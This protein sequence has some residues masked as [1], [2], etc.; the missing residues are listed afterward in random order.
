VG[1]DEGGVIAEFPAVVNISKSLPAVKH[2]VEHI[3]ETLCP[4]PVASRYR[5]L[6]PEK[7]E[8]ARAEFAELEKQG[9]VRRSSSSWSSP[10]HMVPKADGSWRP[11]GDYRRLNLVTVPD[12]YP[13]PHMEDLS[14]RLA[15][16]VIFSKLDLRKG[17][18]Q[19]PV[20]EK[21]VAK[22]AIITPFGLFEFLRMPFGLRNAGQSFQRLMDHIM[23]GLQHVFVYMDD[24]LVASKSRAEHH[25][26][27]REVMKRLSTHGLVLNK[28]KCV[29]YASEVEYL[30]H[31]VSAKGIR[32]LAAR[33]AAIEDFPP[34][35]T[36]GE[37][38]RFLGMV[39]YYRRFV[40]G[41]AA[42]LKPLTDA[43]RGPGGQSTQIVM[44]DDMCTAFSEA[45]MALV[46]AAV[47]V[48]PLPSA[49]ISL[50]VDA[51]DKHVG[52]GPA[53]TG[54]RSV[55]PFGLLQQKVD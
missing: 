41:A 13:P 46:K 48:H 27:V 6:D 28:E 42:I 50:A 45:K 55:A 11:C 12:M 22:T 16:K 31:N 26:H 32:P 38:Q 49:E 19:V 53:A 35:T 2:G 30:G 17:Y 20:A 29:F 25:Q 8:I 43:T 54:E 9:I 15:G 44:T 10:L 39:N 33:V 40:K 18:Y 23:A 51:S 24:I 5:R 36:R 14:A 1:E 7:L 47:L 4:R 52:G 34:P 37:L 3:I 21:D